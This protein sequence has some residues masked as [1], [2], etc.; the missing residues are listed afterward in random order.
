M[1]QMPPPVPPIPADSSSPA[2]S[3]ASEAIPTSPQL[4]PVRAIP[5]TLKLLPLVSEAN[6][7]GRGAMNSGR[8]LTAVERE[9]PRSPERTVRT[10]GA[11]TP[12]K[13]LGHGKRR[14]MSVGEADL[15]KATNTALT[16][17]PP[18]PASAREKRSEDSMGWDSTI[19]GIFSEFGKEPSQLDHD[20]T[21]AN[22]LGLRV[23][24][25]SRLRM[26]SAEPTTTATTPPDF[27]QM[28]SSP[29]PLV[30][31][32]P[33]IVA[34]APDTDRVSVRGESTEM[35]ESGVSSRTPPLFT[36]TSTRAFSYSQR[37]FPSAGSRPLG[38]RSASSAHTPS[39]SRERLLAHPRPVACNSEPS[40]V[41][42]NG[43]SPLSAF[44]HNDF[45]TSPSHQLRRLPS[46]SLGTTDSDVI[47][48]RG[49]ECARR[50]WEEDEGFLTK[51]RFAEWLG[52]L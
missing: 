11:T 34:H 47:E 8:P 44:S 13:T 15:K 5:D 2:V 30:K 48:T 1:I 51:E 6:V 39:G 38:P 26:R 7:K 35:P 19:R 21:E 28:A 36:G 12:V 27:R 17:L 22:P 41:T 43:S 49:K 20:P 10:H 29:P 40:L 46:D 50:A 31:P 14:S 24:S 33:T 4:T 25:A 32:N 45:T 37:P 23:P 18:V 16:T 52:G 9:S 3:L 42:T